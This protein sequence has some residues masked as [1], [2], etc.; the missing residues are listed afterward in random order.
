M[1]TFTQRDTQSAEKRAGSRRELRFALSGAVL[2]LRCRWFVG[3]LYNVH[4]QRSVSIAYRQEF[5][6]RSDAV[7][8]VSRCVSGC[9]V[10]L[11]SQ[12]P[13]DADVHEGPDRQGAD[14]DLRFPGPCSS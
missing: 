8:L 12:K 10:V 13:L 2:L 3:S 9:A 1:L 6:G 11:G 5:G 7:V 14:R 4:A